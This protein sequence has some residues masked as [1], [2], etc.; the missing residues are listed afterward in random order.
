MLVILKFLIIFQQGAMFPFCTLIHKFSVGHCDLQGQEHPQELWE[1]EEEA[2]MVE[3]SQ[4]EG[5]QP[6]GAGREESTALKDQGSCVPA[7]PC[8]WPSSLFF[9]WL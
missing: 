8:P 2:G 3:G 7:A 1:A 4:A 6:L 9:L 5:L